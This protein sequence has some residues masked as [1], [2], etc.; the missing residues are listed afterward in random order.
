M[1]LI[2]SGLFVQIDNGFVYYARDIGSKA[3]L[4]AF[5]SI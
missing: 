3:T 2:K 4:E 1:S 5:T